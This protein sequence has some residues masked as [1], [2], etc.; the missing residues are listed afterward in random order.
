VDSLKKWI[1]QQL[2]DYKILI[3]INFISQNTKNGSIVRSNA[4]A[5]TI[6]LK[7][8][9]LPKAAT[10]TLLY[11]CTLLFISATATV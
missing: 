3:W 1:N 8:T 9:S 5:T 2:E 10:A 4:V 7:S 11:I 6:D